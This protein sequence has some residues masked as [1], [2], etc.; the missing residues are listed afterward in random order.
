MGAPKALLP[1]GEG[2]VFVTRLLHTFFAAGI[3]DVTVVTG[4]IHDRIVRAVAADAVGGAMVR[5]ARNPDPGRGQLSSLLTGL[6][7]A[8]APGVRGVLLTLVDIPF[9][10]PGT[11]GAVVDAFTQTGAP[12]VRPT[13]GDDHGHPVLFARSLFHELRT[14]DPGQG[15]K[16]V[17]R[18]H[19][20][21]ILNLEVDDD[22]ALLD[23]DTRDEY[24]RL[25][26]P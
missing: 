23:L 18:A 11:V 9:V 6:D 8:D 25:L 15:A 24:E 13:R 20:A 7:A 14:A 17:V 1:D 16:A 10:A 4:A 22:G 5:F 19:V 21:E 12:I 3:S 26:K 2:R